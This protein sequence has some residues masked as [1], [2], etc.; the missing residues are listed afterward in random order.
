MIDLDLIKTSVEYSLKKLELRE[1]VI[2]TTLYQLENFL[3]PALIERLLDYIEKN[4]INWEKETGQYES[5]RKKVNWIAD[6]PIEE[7]HT[8]FDSVT[9]SVNKIFN[10]NNKFGGIS[11][12]KDE[13]GYSISKHTDNPVIDIAIQIYLTADQ[14]IDAGTVF[15]VDNREVKI[16][17]KINSGY[18]MD[19]TAKIEHYM[20]GSIPENFTR[21]SVYA[22]WTKP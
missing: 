7:L 5:N 8:V 14:K 9:E 4:D 1:S 12:W 15:V 18:I 19:N 11:I 10:R 21:Y 2:T 13:L 3:Y 6:S 20:N 16:L 17:F 22:F